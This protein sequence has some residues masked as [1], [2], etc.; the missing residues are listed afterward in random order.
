MIQI[1]IRKYNMKLSVGL[2]HGRLLSTYSENK[3]IF[4]LERISPN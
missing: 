3:K 2:N 1:G 4:T